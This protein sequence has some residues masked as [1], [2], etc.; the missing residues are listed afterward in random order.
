MQ[1][2]LPCSYL[3]Y[4]SITGKPEGRRSIVFWTNGK[5]S[6]TAAVEK[7][8]TSNYTYSR[9]N[10]SE[11]ESKFHDTEKDYPRT[12]DELLQ[13]KVLGKKQYYGL[14]LTM[15]DFHLRNVAYENRTDSEYI[16]VYEK[17]SSSFL[18]CVFAD[19]QSQGTDLNDLGKHLIKYWRL[20]P[21]QSFTE[22]F[23]TSDNPSL[24]FGEAKTIA[25][26]FLP[27]HPNLGVIAFDKRKLNLKSAR[28][29]IDDVALLNGFQVQMSIRHVFSDHDLSKI[30]DDWKA[31][32]NIANRAKPE[33]WSNEEVWHPG[34]IP[35]AGQAPE[36]LSFIEFA[37]S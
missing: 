8:A 25:A 9:V 13:A 30:K 22:K 17:M 11:A 36:R 29:T 1:H 6:R 23:I 18:A 34:F 19:T 4:F 24:V 14:I 20:Q 16:D 32:Q 5:I 21:V 33:R 3:Q 2:W 37:P 12:I 27:V 31:L 15:F 35:Y 7:L 28:A 26:I 10:P